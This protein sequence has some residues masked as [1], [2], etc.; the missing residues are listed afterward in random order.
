MG[1]DWIEGPPTKDAPSGK[2]ILARRHRHGEYVAIK[3]GCRWFY[4]TGDPFEIVVSEYSAH[5]LLEAAQPA[6]P[7][8]VEP[9]PFPLLARWVENGR[10]IVA[11]KV[12]PKDVAQQWRVVGEITPDGR[13]WH[14]D[15]SIPAN[16]ECIDPN[17]IIAE[18]DAAVARVKELEAERDG[19]RAEVT[20]LKN[21]LA[22][23]HYEA[24]V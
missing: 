17:A 8:K 9:A 14:S 12:D 18:R 23:I 5:A 7:E 1:L 6:P 21:K 2:Y 11:A 24:E 16:A 22:V 20:R 15:S 10:S 19:L 13:R 4:T 3:S